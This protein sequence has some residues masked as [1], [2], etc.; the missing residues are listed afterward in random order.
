M[1]GSQGDAQRGIKWLVLTTPQVY[2]QPQIF[3]GTIFPLWW[4]ISGPEKHWELFKVTQQSQAFKAD[5][6]LLCPRIFP[7]GFTL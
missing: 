3:Q 7:T 5:L 6:L 4:P 2:I 1:L